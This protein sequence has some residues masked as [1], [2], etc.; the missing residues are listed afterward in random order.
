[1]N[2]LS[3]VM[4]EMNK[5]YKTYFK[6]YRLVNYIL[7]VNAGILLFAGAIL[8]IIGIIKDKDPV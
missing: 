2:Q 1:M 4:L 7:C 3:D 6:K 8:A 5:F